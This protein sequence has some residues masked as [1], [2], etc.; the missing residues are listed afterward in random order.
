MK[1]VGLY[2]GTKHSTMTALGQFGYSLESIKLL[3]RHK[4]STA[5]LRYAQ[6]SQNYGARDEVLAKQS[7]APEK[8]ADNGF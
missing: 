6:M 5:A 7:E 8:A 3:S 4:T 1:N 2:A